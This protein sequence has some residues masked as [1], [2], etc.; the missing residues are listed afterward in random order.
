M[1]PQTTNP[2]A[3]IWPS[4]TAVLIAGGPSLTAGQVEYLRP[5]HARGD[6]RVAGVNDAYRICDFLDL[7]Y[8]ADERWWQAHPHA[9]ADLRA[10]HVTAPPGDATA[11]NPTLAG[12][13]LIRIPGRAAPSI[14]TDPS[15]IHLGMN[16]GFQLLN[17]AVQAGATRII[18]LG[19]DMAMGPDG[20]RHWFGDHPP[21]LNRDSPYNKFAACFYAAAADIAA[22]GTE[23]INASPGSA[24]R[25]FQAQRLEDALL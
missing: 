18:L 25:C 9:Q 8:A 5:R 14:S 2:L 20:R 4:S 23:V 15:H 3:G 7:L 24:L 13:G 21:G 11:S 19:Y 17:I 6:I 16:S 12:L 1:P 22:A 10:I